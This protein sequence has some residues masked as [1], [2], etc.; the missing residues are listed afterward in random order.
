MLKIEND[1]RAEKRHTFS[2]ILIALSLALAACNKLEQLDKPLPSCLDVELA[3][4]SILIEGG[5]FLFGETR[6][7]PEEGPVAKIE[8]KSF[9]IDATEVTNGQFEK[10]VKATGYITEAEKGLSAELYP[11][12]PAE[13]RAPGSAVFFQPDQ[14]SDG[15]TD[16]WWQFVAGASWKSPLGPE[17]SIVE[18]QHY[19]VIHVTYS[20]ALAYASW[21]GRRVPTEQ[22][23]EYAARGGHSGAT[24]AWGEEPPH[25]GKSKANTWQGNFPYKNDGVDGFKGAAPVG[26]FDPNN[27]GLYDMTGNLWEWTETA[28]HADRTMNY[29]SEGNDPRQPGVTLKSIKGGSFLCSDNYCQR[30][31]PAARQGQD[32]T[33]ATSHI[34]FRTAADVVILQP[35]E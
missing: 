30:Y 17:S 2:F 1:F 14:M 33:M 27:Y 24:Y 26:C 11:Q 12:I 35:G 4:E 32:I 5:E 6:Y 3:N 9:E 21:L 25:T 28:Y 22:E 34:G 15:K 10:F 16:G 29:R 8:V 13:F 18:R 20:D 7:Y 23:W 19:P 31:R